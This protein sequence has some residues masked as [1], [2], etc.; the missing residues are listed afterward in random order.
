MW[1]IIVMVILCFIKGPLTHLWFLDYLLYVVPF[2]FW[3]YYKT[4][5]IYFMV[6]YNDL[7]TFNCFTFTPKVFYDNFYLTYIRLSVSSFVSSSGEVS[8]L[9]HKCSSPIFFYLPVR[10]CYWQWILLQHDRSSWI[11][12][13]DCRLLHCDYVSICVLHLYE[14]FVL[15]HTT[16]LAWMG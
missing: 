10:D 5:N 4:I 7:W 3:P 12:H 13:C 14:Y 16:L 6:L 15:S 8:L 1:K 2:T 9:I 11:F